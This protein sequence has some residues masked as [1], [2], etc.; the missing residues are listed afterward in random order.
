MGTSRKNT[1]AR[2]RKLPRSWKVA[3]ADEP[4]LDNLQG[5]PGSRRS[6]SS[7]TC[8]GVKRVRRPRGI[9][10]AVAYLDGLC[11]ASAG[12][13]SVSLR[14]ERSAGFENKEYR[15][16]RNTCPTA[17][18]TFRTVLIDTLA[19]A[20]LRMDSPGSSRSTASTR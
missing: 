15:H 17:A 3:I 16:Q 10:C 13:A 1:H 19:T 6:R 7:A 5:V 18:A 12:R 20:A 14:H 4:R 2:S 8:C 9:P 11:Y